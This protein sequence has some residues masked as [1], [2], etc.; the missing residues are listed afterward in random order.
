MGAHANFD[1]VTKLITLT[2]APDVNGEV[3]LDTLIDL[4]SDA[5]EDWLADPV[6]RRKFALPFRVIGGDDLGGG[7]DAGAYFFLRNDLGWR[8]RPYEGHHSLTIT[9]NLYA[10]DVNLPITVPTLGAYTVSFRLTTSSLTQRVASKQQIAEEVRV[11]LTP[12][13]ANMDTT[14]SSRATQSSVD[15]MQID[16][17][18]ISLALSTVPL[19][20]WE[21]LLTGTFPV[22]SMGEKMQQVLTTGNFLALK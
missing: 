12:E 9:G 3:T 17:D 2:T 7:I 5:K 10:Q 21:E 14:V 6:L 4:Y 18:A 15:A 13:L 1:P 8:I 22:G 19:D 11:E 16:I 20:T